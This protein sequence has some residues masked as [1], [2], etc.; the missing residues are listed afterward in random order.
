VPELPIVAEVTNWGAIIMGAILI[1]TSMALVRVAWRLDNQKRIKGVAFALIPLAL[2]LI[3]ALRDIGWQLRIDQNGIAVRAPFD[4]FMPS[5]EIAWPDVTAVDI[6]THWQRGAYYRLRIRGQHGAELLIHGAGRMPPQ[7]VGQLQ[8]V[9]ARL[10]PQV[11]GIKNLDRQFQ[12]AR[13]NSTWGT[14]YSYSVRD[15]RGVL[16]R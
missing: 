11:T 4:L 3:P 15:G 10:A 5:G 8:A 13:E 1:V 7:F 14:L 9:V 12:D 2:G 16:L 6:V